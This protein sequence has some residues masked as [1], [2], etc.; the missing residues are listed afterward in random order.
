MPFPH[1]SAATGSSQ[2][3]LEQDQHHPHGTLLAL[4][5]LVHRFP[6][7]LHLTTN[8][9]LDIPRSPY[10]RLGQSLASNPDLPS[11]PRVW[12]RIQLSSPLSL[13]FGWASGIDCACSFPIQ[14][15]LNQAGKSPPE[16]AITQNGSTSWSGPA[17]TTMMAD[18]LCMVFHK[19]KVSLRLH[20]KILSNVVSKFHLNQSI[21]L[22]VFYPKPHASPTDSSALS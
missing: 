15:I 20:P 9:A 13:V 8:Q 16:L 11:D 3:L 1:S 22:P 4:S 6:E 10:A 12:H 14:Q 19:D 17:A 5:I 18:P 7:T 21:H 2:D